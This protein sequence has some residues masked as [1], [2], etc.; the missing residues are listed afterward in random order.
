VFTCQCSVASVHLLV[1]AVFVCQSRSMLFMKHYVC[2]LDRFVVSCSGVS[3][4]SAM[5][6]WP[7][8]VP[9]F[10]HASLALMSSVYSRLTIAHEGS[11]STTLPSQRRTF[12]AAHGGC[13]CCALRSGASHLWWRASGSKSEWIYLELGI[14]AQAG[15]KLEVCTMVDIL[16]AKS[17]CLFGNKDCV[18]GTS[19]AFS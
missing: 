16:A 1:L 2:C 10:M 5:V 13:W 18:T 15:L 6:C 7:G 14:E 3:A 4:T 8:S 17:A 11:F 19:F 12:A 9:L